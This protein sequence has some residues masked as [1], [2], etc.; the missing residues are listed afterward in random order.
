MS[1]TRGRSRKY[2]ISM[3]DD[4]GTWLDFESRTGA[5]QGNVSLTIRR[6]LWPIYQEF[7]RKQDIAKIKEMLVS[8]KLPL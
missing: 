8:G 2:S 1:T 7:L 5:D 6:L 3:S 4:M